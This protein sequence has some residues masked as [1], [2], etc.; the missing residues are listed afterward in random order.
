MRHCPRSNAAG[1]P[2]PKSK[3]YYNYEYAI[4]FLRGG[5][6]ASQSLLRL[7][8]FLNTDETWMESAVGAADL[9]NVARKRMKPRLGRQI[10]KMSL[11]TELEILGSGFLQRW[12]ALSQSAFEANDIVM[13]FTLELRLCS[14]S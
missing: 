11:L 14:V 6:Q 7:H 13:S 9:W 10:G 4:P 1:R 3:N 8:F 12:R 5:L 2:V